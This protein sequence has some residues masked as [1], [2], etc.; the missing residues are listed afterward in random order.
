[1]DV[2]I[3]NKKTF[4]TI[5]G[6]YQLPRSDWFMTIKLNHIYMTHTLNNQNTTKFHNQN[7]HVNLVTVVEK[8]SWGQTN[9][10]NYRLGTKNKIN[11]NRSC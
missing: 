11:V 4:I 9:A 5:T 3:A 10:K 1:M 6:K 7:V 2:P 8:F